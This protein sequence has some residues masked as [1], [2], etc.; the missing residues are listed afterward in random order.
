LKKK[1]IPRLLHWSRF[2]IQEIK[3]GLEQENFVG[4]VFVAFGTLGMLPPKW[5]WLG[6]SVAVIAYISVY[7]FFR[8]EILG[9]FSKT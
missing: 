7:K 2:A 1:A 4:S 3:L 5:E 9:R 6:A 8:R